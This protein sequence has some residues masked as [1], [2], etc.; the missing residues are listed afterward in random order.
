MNGGFQTDPREAQILLA[1]VQQDF[2]YPL[3][4]G[5]WLDSVCLGLV[6]V[7]ISHYAFTAY[8]RDNVWVRGL[9]LYL[10]AVACVATALMVLQVFVYVVKGFGSY[11]AMRWITCMSMFTPCTGNRQGV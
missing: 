6:L 1:A 3:I 5:L 9:V 8:K 11:S 2:L 10:M 4:I 7:L